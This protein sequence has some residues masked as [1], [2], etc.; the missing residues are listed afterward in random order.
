MRERG[1]GE[2]PKL[3]WP[4]LFAESVAMKSTSLVAAACIALSMSACAMD[5]PCAPQGDACG[6]DPDRTMDRHRTAAAIPPTQNPEAVT[7]YDQTQNMARQPPPEPTSSDWCSYLI[8]DP[9]QGITQ[10]TF[11]HDTLAIA[12]RPRHLR[13]H[14]DVR[15]PAVDDRQRQRRHLREPAS[16]ASRCISSARRRT[17]RRRPASVRSPTI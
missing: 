17:R 2:G 1:Q 4:Q 3:A 14:R 8:Y 11:P 12:H 5:D 15:R 13:R 7:Y 10:F 16:P 6:G 9:N